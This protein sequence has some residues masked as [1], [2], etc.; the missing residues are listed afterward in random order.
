[1]EHEPTG[2]R[3]RL[4]AELR[5]L[6]GNA[7]L[8][9]DEV[10][11]ELS[12][13]TSKISRLENGKGI[14]KPR[15]IEDLIRIYHVTADLEQSML[16]RLVHESRSQ[17]WW[18]T[19]TD[20]L[21]AERFV[22]DSPGRYAAL[23]TDAVG[24]ASFD[25]AVLH[26]LAQTPDYARAILGALLPRHEAWELDRLVDLRRHRQRALTVATGPLRLLDVIDEG[27]LRRVVGSPAVMAAQ[28]DRLLELSAM[29]N[30][31]LQVLPFDAGMHRAH[32]GQFAI[33]EIPDE[34]GSDVVYTESHAG[35]TYLTDASDVLLYRG[36][37][38][39]V[40]ARAQGPETT[41]DTLLRYRDLHLSAEGAAR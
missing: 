1:M 10:G 13:S 27:A 6:R 31:D 29:P 3:R 38:D 8:R 33:L 11:K 41:R 35:D 24:I 25:L 16:R 12:C 17:G 18:E 37:L 9:L 40:R 15:D 34:R 20:G 23:E 4:G 28:M 26:G 7:G 22:L 2:A 21:S 14:P 32:S 30:V 5:R 36:I 19:Y 39:D